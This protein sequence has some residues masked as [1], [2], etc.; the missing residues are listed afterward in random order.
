MKQD[1]HDVEVVLVDNGGWTEGIHR[2]IGSIIPSEILKIIREE[3]PG[4]RAA[5]NAGLEACEGRF[6]ARMD[7]DDIM[8]PDRLRLQADELISRPDTDVTGG[9]V[10]LIG[11]TTKA[12]GMLNY[13][14]EVNGLLSHNDMYHY[15]YI[16]APLI[17]PSIMFRR[18]LLRSEMYQAADGE[19]E[20]YSLILK[21]MHQG[22]KFSK[23]NDRVLYW[24]DSPTRLT[25]VHP[26]Y[27]REAF[28][29]V[30]LRYLPLSIR[31]K[32]RGRDLW[33]WGAGKYARRM[34]GSLESAG[35]RIKGIIDIVRN[36]TVMEKPS[37]HYTDLP[38]DGE[39]FVLSVV[40]N[41]GKHL[42][43]RDHLNSLGYT[44][45]NDFIRCS[46]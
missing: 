5:L 30:R 9:I 8:T 21:L 13:V 15:R 6:I 14:T 44:E 28:N 18:T 2:T 11:E 38:S 43:I 20:D 12:D 37:M 25:R 26:D 36:K 7:A 33:V 10:E 32:L 19:P 3:T 34:I 31:K 24:R 22:I 16:D 4:I 39:I 45:G 46:P 42:E 17:H 29:R 27:S 41:R 23:V 1:L 35:V 40:S